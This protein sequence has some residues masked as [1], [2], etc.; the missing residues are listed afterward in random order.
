MG[1]A[2][3]TRPETAASDPSLRPAGPETAEVAG[4]RYVDDSRPGIRRRR[5]G[6]QFDYLRADGTRVTDPRTLKRIGALAIPP[7]WTDVWICPLPNGHIQ[8]TGRDAK[9]RKQ[10]RYHPRWREA[11]DETKYDRMLAFGRALP[12]IRARVAED[13]AK[14]GLSREKVLAT[15]VRLLETTFIRVGNEEYA[16]K[17]D[18]F[19]LTTLRDQH[20]AINGSTLELHFRG[21]SGVE[22][23]V[24]LRDRRL[25][26]I[27]QQCQHL[28][29]QEL[30]QYVDENGE[31]R[32]VG[33]NDV[34][35]YLREISGQDF[36]AKD[37]RTWAGTV[38]AFHALR[39]R[40]QCPTDR[41]AKKHVVE[42]IKDVAGRLGNTPAVCRKCYVH[43]AVLE[44]YLDGTT[45]A[46]LG[47]VCCEP[48]GHE[49]KA[50]TEDEA[51]VMLFL[52]S[53][54]P[55][56]RFANATPPSLPRAA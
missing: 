26:R 33:S 38:L 17:N 42:V 12:Q 20:A 16:R 22:H 25:A 41:E 37:F 51:A 13:M 56:S 40:A 10:Y 24:R 21:K 15:L 11:R 53:R 5:R 18:S 55:Q 7:A 39:K 32:T 52:A 9:G 3:R 46:T 44:T 1:S 14:P 29:G 30:F 49:W 6:R 2:A 34:N 8:A 4:L 54:N 28:P 31:R 36:T 50:L 19:G 48:N 35:D 27:V 23:H 47:A 43:P 45:R